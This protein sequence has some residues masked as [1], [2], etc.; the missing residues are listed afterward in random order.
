M[1][2]VS[3]LIRRGAQV[4]SHDQQRWT[5]LHLAASQGHQ[6]IIDPLLR[7]KVETDAKDGYGA[8]ALY[9]AAE[10]GHEAAAQLLLIEGARP[11]IPNDYD[12]TPLHR[13]ADLG[14][15]ATARL[16]L[17]HGAPY[18]V[19]DYYGWTPLYRA[20]DHGH[21]EVADLLADFAEAARKRSSQ[22]VM[23]LQSGSETLVTRKSELFVHHR[24]GIDLHAVVRQL[25][26]LQR[27]ELGGRGRL[28]KVEEGEE[29]EENRTA[30]LNDEEKAPFSDDV[31]LGRKAPNAKR[32]QRRK[33]WIGRRKR[34][35]DGGKI[36]MGGKSLSTSNQF[37]VPKSMEWI[38]KWNIYKVWL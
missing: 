28:R 36:Y 34:W 31:T 21:N 25:F 23:M 14:R 22:Q 5:T 8:T 33:Q 18:N 16:L 29:R 17:N 15:L 30:P 11:D 26:L 12:Q 35:R 10:G 3:L 37:I 13:A 27:Q 38:R 24:A 19:K 4:E 1:A 20:A 32:H 9:R 7:T 2:V 6:E